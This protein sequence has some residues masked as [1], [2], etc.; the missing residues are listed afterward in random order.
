MRRL[1]LTSAGQTLMYARHY[2]EAGALLGA[3]ARGAPNAAQLLSLA[4]LCRQMRRH[5][6]D[7]AESV[8]DDPTSVVKR[9]LMISTSD[10]WLSDTRALSSSHSGPDYEDERKLDEMLRDFRRSRN[11]LRSSGSPVDVTTDIALAA[12]ETT[13]DGDEQSGYRVQVSSQ[14]G[15]GGE[16]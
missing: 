13:V 3:G 14:Q 6:D 1:A 8:A 4:S 11:R 9:V 5:E 7:E 12:M 2:G 10:D 16:E 15:N